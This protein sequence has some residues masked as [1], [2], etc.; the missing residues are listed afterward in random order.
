MIKMREPDF[1]KTT[2]EWKAINCIWKS[3]SSEQKAKLNK[4]FKLLVQFIRLHKQPKV[5]SWAKDNYAYLSKISPEAKQFVISMVEQGKKNIYHS[6]M[7]IINNK[8][9][10]SCQ[11]LQEYY[12]QKY[13]QKR[14]YLLENKAYV[15]EVI[16]LCWN[17]FHDRR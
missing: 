1:I 5:E 17:K 13:G 2:D 3:C 7:A 10:L 8:P 12:F 9:E 16:E 15:S 4:E 11:E 6:L 14:P